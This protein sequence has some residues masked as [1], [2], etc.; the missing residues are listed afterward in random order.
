MVYLKPAATLMNNLLRTPF[1]IKLR[2]W[3]YWSSKV[4][5][6]PLYPYWAWLSLKAGSF[7]FL[8]TANP[9]IK[10]GGF[11][12]ESKKDVYN[13]LPEAYYPETLLFQ[14]GT[15]VA[16]ISDAI[17]G[18]EITYPFIAKPDIG[19]RGLGVKKIDNL[20]ELKRY[21]VNMPVPF[22]VQQFVPYEKEVG[23][24]YCK[25]PAAS[26]GFISGIVNKEPVTVTG[27]GKSTL[28]MLVKSNDRY[29][30]QL[31]QIKALYPHLMDAVIEAGKEMVLVPYGNHSRGSKQ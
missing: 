18:T 25:L 20:E 9:K 14:P 6:A 17:E 8:T 30:L 26:E 21:A 10:N 28:T 15:P 12:M 7:Y 31:K 29:L 23:I 3:E 24:F 22:L 13:L 16:A 1:F 11:I 4:V 2:H 19:E 27:D 5:Y